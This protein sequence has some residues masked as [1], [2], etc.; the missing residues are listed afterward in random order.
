MV[1]FLARCWFYRSI[2]R[3]VSLPR[4]DYVYVHEWNL[5]PLEAARISEGNFIDSIAFQLNS[6]D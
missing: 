1:F 6:L 2:A 5:Q 4:W 3:A